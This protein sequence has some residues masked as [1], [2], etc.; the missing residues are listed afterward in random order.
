MPVMPATWE[1][2]ARSQGQFGKILSQNEI[3]GLEMQ[4]TSPWIP[5]RVHSPAKKRACM[6][7]E[8]F[9]RGAGQEVGLLFNTTDWKMCLASV[10]PQLT[11]I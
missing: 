10:L 4:L 9:H 8:L 11:P 7:I 3:K 6:Y 2:E 5:T 1:A